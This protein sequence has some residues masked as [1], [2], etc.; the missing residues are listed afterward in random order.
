LPYSPI[1]FKSFFFIKADTI[2]QLV[3][4][5][6]GEPEAAKRIL[7]NSDSVLADVNGLQILIVKQSA[8]DPL[9]LFFNRI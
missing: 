4:K 7:P 3:A 8:L 1:I 2:K 9:D 6:Y 5:Y